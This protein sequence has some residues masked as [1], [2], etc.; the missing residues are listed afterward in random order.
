MNMKSKSP[1]SLRGATATQSTLSPPSE[2][3]VGR[4]EEARWFGQLG[5]PL[6]PLLRRWER[7][8]KN[9]VEQVDATPFS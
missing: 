5:L 3:G 2:G 7:K 4:G 6:S 9:A 8:K 1:H